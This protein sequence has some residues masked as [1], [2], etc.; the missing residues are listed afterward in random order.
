MDKSW[1]TLRGLRF[2]PL[3]HA[4]NP[5]GRDDCKRSTSLDKSQAM[6][7]GLSF[8]PLFAK[9]GISGD[10]AMCPP[11]HPPSPVGQPA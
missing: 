9:L 6:L 1:A 2:A 3:C 7:K 10:G 5:G 8:S 4:E 11:A